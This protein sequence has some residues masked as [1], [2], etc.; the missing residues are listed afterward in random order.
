MKTR[1]QKW[2][3]MILCAAMCIGMLP[4]F[5]M[6]TDTPQ[7]QKRNLALNKDVTVSG[8]EVNDGRLTGEMAVDGEV[9]NTSRW[10]P[11]KLDNQW[12]VVD[13]GDEYRIDQIIINFS[14]VSPEYKVLVSTTNSDDETDWT[15]V[16][17]VSTEMDKSTGVAEIVNI[18]LDTPVTARYVKYQQLQMWPHTNGQKYSG[19][20]YEL[21]VYSPDE[22]E[23]VDTD[24]NLA[25]ERPVSVSTEQ[26]GS[27]SNYNPAVHAVDGDPS[28]RWASN[29]DQF[30]Q[31]FI[32][33]LGQTCDITRFV[34]NFY[35]GGTNRSYQ[36][37]IA[38]S[39]T[40]KESDYTVVVDRSD[41]STRAW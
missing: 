12:L 4:G 22:L 24:V 10:S 31:W 14:A 25:L 39:E 36:Y 6:A 23:A 3:A 32:V 5:A 28:T 21:E 11:A 2:I 8:T 9:S 35:N 41:N 26:V 33:D 13:L 34:C 29:D 37:Q 20:I 17:S 30:P 40:G 1:L 27:G 18:E 15:E 19:S 16:H 38:V 7:T